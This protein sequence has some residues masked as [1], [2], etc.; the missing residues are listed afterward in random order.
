M[1]YLK[2]LRHK[3]VDYF[4][5][6]PIQK[7]VYKNIFYIFITA[8]SGFVFS[9]GFKCFIQ[10]NYHAIFATEGV[11]QTY[12][13]S[14]SVKALASCG[15]SGISQVLITIMKL[16]GL[17]YLTDNTLFNITYWAFYLGINVP[18]ITFAFFKIGKRFALYSLLNV[19]FASLFGIIIPNGAPTDI[20]NQIAY[21][22]GDN[23]G[24][25][26]V[27][28]AITTGVASALAYIIESTAG[29][30]DIIAYYISEKKS[31]LIG[32]WSALFNCV[33][34]AFYL[35]LNCFSFRK[36]FVEANMAG[37]QVSQAII[38]FLLMIVYMFGVSFVVDK[39]NTNNKKAELQII[40][41]SPNIK[42]AIISN[43]PHSC[44]IVKS[45]GGYSG[46]ER[47]I[48]YMSVRQHEVKKVVKICKKI[49]KNVFIN[50]M[51]MEQVYGSFY[52][53]Q[54][55]WQFLKKVHFCLVL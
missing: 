19:G 49:D 53:K 41:S 5:D 3:V 54:I 13:D 36:E 50:V 26:I 42:N 30:T 14:I 2:K 6:H 12:V 16:M 31:V 48:I 25:R 40:T 35:I 28:A 27:F 51:A 7:S 11:T 33:I 17:T 24:L 10:P 1:Y 9:V 46:Q 52:R 43:T 32:K 38:V 45:E 18:L 23:I 20:I 8:L 55:K 37:M 15:A 22:I 34:V 39:I 44:T 47:F 21:A 4:Y 29:G